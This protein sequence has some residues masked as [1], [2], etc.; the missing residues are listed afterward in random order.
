MRRFLTTLTIAFICG[1]LATPTIE[2][3]NRRGGRNG[4]T[5]EQT[6]RSNNKSANRQERKQPS[7]NNNN[8][9]RVD[10]KKKADAQ[11]PA[12][13]GNISQGNNRP[14]QPANNGNMSNSQRPG[15]N[16]QP[17][18]N[19][20]MNQGQRPGNN[21]QPAHNGNMNQG[22]RPDNNR[23]PAQNGNMNQ[24]Q[25]PG[26]KPQPP[27]NSHH[28]GDNHHRPAHIAPPARP[29][30]PKAHVYH[31]PVPPPTI[32]YH[33]RCPVITTILGIHLGTAFNISLNYLY[34]NGYIVDGYG[35]DMIY[36]RNAPQLS[37][38]WPD[39][40]LHYGPNGLIGSEFSYSTSH[41]D[42]SRYNQV[43]ST[44]V[45]QYGSPVSYK[46]SGGNITATWWGREGYVQLQF[47]HDYSYNG[48]LRYYTTLSFGL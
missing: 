23:Q 14:Q 5:T 34:N 17:T 41:Y 46:S 24:G 22:Q 4:S 39:A 37:L 3:Q 19:G 9:N 42:M 32:V 28:Y 25:R 38:I 16:R 8:S 47:R 43:Y 35:N 12:N 30:R 36:L 26:N 33:S 15:N 20:N 10:N 1:I 18:H 7:R 21:R 44:F 13:R 2:A 40:I 27:H 29:H 6:Q 31:R 45:T 48:Q 11:Q